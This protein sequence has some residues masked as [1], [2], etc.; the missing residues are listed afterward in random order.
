MKD[1]RLTWKFPKVFWIANVIELFERAAYYGMFIA[2]VVFLTS[3]VGFSDIEAG[4]I[5]G[6]FAALLYLGPI[7]NG[8]LADRLGFRNALLLAFLVLTAGYAALG[9]FPTKLFSVIS[10]A[11]IVFGGSFIKPVISGTVAKITDDVNRARAYS[12]FYQMVNIGSFSGKTIA[13]PLRTELGLEY[14][15]YYAAFI[16]LIA[17]FVV[18]FF[19]KSVEIQAKGKKFKEIFGEFKVV[20]TNFRFMMLIFIVAGF[21]LIQGQ[22][23]ATMPKYTLRL[24]GAHA[25]PEWYANVNP[26]MVVLFVIP[27]THLV[28][29]MRPI[30]SIS[31]SL[32]IIPLSALSISLSPVLESWTGTSVEF[33]GLFSLHPITVMMIIGIALQGLAECFLS[34]RYYEFASKQAPKGQEGLYLGYA[35]IHT[36]IA[37]LVGFA[38]SGYLLDTY[39]PDPRKFLTPQQII[40]IDQFG[41]DPKTLL[42]PEQFAMH[43]GQAHYIW[44]YF[45][46]IGLFALIL[47]LIYR[48]VTDW[49]DQKKLEE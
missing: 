13:K 17:F 24:V 34:P 40:K 44:Y 20:L 47:S 48:W 38:I 12:I 37:W 32:A 36:F 16:S 7:F 6:A 29:H 49:L 5:G 22:L 33:F 15:N 11:L 45:A 43:F 31:I 27:I 21:W 10:L 1:K 23:Y 28:R 46:A 4:W 42:T 8:A 35:H 26:L 19:F 39:A 18:L 14:L 2:L 30:G 9:A 41:I 25:A 3:V